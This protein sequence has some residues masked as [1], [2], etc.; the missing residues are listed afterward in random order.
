MLV[1]EISPSYLELVEYVSPNPLDLMSA[2]LTSSPSSPS[3][4]HKFLR[5]FKSFVINDP[6]EDLGHVN[7][8]LDILKGNAL[9]AIRSIG[10][11]GVYNPSLDL[12]HVYLV[13]LPRKIKCT[14]FFDHSFDFSEAY[15]KF[16]KALTI[17]DV[18][19]LVL[20]YIHS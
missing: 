10:H 9:D 6:N 3:S 16:M 14:I 4:K 20:S 8:L 17:I 13:G 5:P 19:L 11:F 7:H 2:S 15:N 18:V 1:H 12:F